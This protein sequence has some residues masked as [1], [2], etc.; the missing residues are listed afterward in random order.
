MRKLLEQFPASGQC[1]VDYCQ[2][3]GISHWQFRYWRRRLGF[4]FRK[5]KDS[6]PQLPTPQPAEFVRLG[7]LPVASP[8]EEEKPSWAFEV[9]FPNGVVFRGSQELALKGLDRIRRLGR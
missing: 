4:R 2:Q 8:A 9:S 5:L 6:L 7:S 1:A 3:N